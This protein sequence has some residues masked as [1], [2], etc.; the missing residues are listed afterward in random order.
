[1]TTDSP[2]RP[3]PWG[4]R[5]FFGLLGVILV[6]VLDLI[7][8]EKLDVLGM[9]DLYTKVAI[10]SGAS[11]AILLIVLLFLANLWERN[12]RGHWEVY[13]MGE[14]RNMRSPVIVPFGN[15]R[16]TWCTKHYGDI[17]L[18][19]R[20]GGVFPCAPKLFYG[21]NNLG[22]ALGH[23]FAETRR[24]GLVR[25]KTKYGDQIV[26]Y[27][28][29]YLMALWSLGL[30]REPKELPIGEFVGRTARRAANLEELERVYDD[31]SFERDTARED[32][33]AE[34][35]STAQLRKDLLAQC[36]RSDEL[37]RALDESLRTNAGLRAQMERVID[38]MNEM[39][40]D[41]MGRSG[42]DGCEPSSPT[43]TV[44][45]DLGGNGV[46][47]WTERD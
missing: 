5:L 9:S 44:T 42:D 7:Y 46:G 4:N 34:R 28:A 19:F 26:M 23:R 6:G 15:L 24:D 10:P 16:K 11:L 33:E 39:R 18:V 2:I 13:W 12:L 43:K 40:E 31:M 36:N 30:V 1:M 41:F 17:A 22:K 20:R 38:D 45:V 29:D 3:I 27:I 37:Q 14:D 47:R 21:A 25:L 32:L 35:R 8:M